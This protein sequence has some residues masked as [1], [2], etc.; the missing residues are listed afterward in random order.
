MAARAHPKYGVAHG[1]V[2]QQEF[3]QILMGI[4]CTGQQKRAVTGPPFAIF[5]SSRDGISL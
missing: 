2:Q 1:E 4:F 3:G 5:P